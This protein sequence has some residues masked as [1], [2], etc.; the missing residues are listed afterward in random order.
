MFLRAADVCWC[1]RRGHGLRL[2]R[3]D[4]PK[5]KRLADAAKTASKVN[6]KKIYKSPSKKKMLLYM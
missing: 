3:N 5:A 1:V 4:K 6:K 2:S